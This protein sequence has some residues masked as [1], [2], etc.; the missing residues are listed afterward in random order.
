[1]TDTTF[2]QNKNGNNEIG[3]NKY[4]NLKNGTIIR[5]ICDTVGIPIDTSS[6]RSDE[7]QNINELVKL[8]NDQ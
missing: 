6:D 5:I 8:H 1:M 7:W 4:Y 2:I 3:Y